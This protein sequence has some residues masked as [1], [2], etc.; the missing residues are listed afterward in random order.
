MALFNKFPVKSKYTSAIMAK[1]GDQ[2]SPSP[3]NESNSASL[4]AEGTNEGNNALGNLLAEALE[5]SPTTVEKPIKKETFDAL[6]REIDNVYNCSPPAS[7]V[8]LFS[9]LQAGGT[10]KNKRSNVKITAAGVSFESRE[11]N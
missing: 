4:A 6:V 8:G 1:K 3:P 2:T 7:L 11:I 10:S 5:L 9:T